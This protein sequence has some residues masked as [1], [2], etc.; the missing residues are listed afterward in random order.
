MVLFL[1]KSMIKEMTL[2]SKQLTILILTEMYH[3]LHHTESTFHNLFGLLGP[4]LSLWISV[5]AIVLLLKSD[6]NKYTSNLKALLCQGI[7]H[8]A[9]YGDVI[10]KLRKIT[11][12]THFHSLFIKRIKT[13]IK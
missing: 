6:S 12:H 5:I 7:S 11:G 10:N 1:L 3:V 9:Y 4:V 2:I 13:I 8:P